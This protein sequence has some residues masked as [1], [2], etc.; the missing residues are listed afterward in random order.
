MLTPAFL[1]N[2]QLAFSLSDDVSLMV[3]GRYLSRTFLANTSDARFVTPAT[4]TMDVAVRWRLGPAT[5]LAQVRNVT[6]ARAFTGG[7][8]DGATSYY[9]VHAARNL[10]I[11]ARVGSEPGDRNQESRAAVRSRR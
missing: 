3:D 9:Y 8:T 4:Y 7:Y 6:N 11:T 2:Q 1:S 10:M 5:W